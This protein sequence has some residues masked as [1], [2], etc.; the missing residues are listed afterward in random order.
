MVLVPFFRNRFCRFLLLTM[1]FIASHQTLGRHPKLLRL[2][3]KLNIHKAQAVGHLQYLWWWALDYAPSGDLSAL[4]QSEI[5]IASEWPG[6][7]SLFRDSLIE[8]GF[9]DSNG[10]IHDWKDH[11][12]NLMNAREWKKKRDRDYQ[13]RRR[14]KIANDSLTIRQRLANDSTAII[15]SRLSKSDKEYKNLTETT[16][17]IALLSGK[18]LSLNDKN[19]ESKYEAKTDIQKIVRGFKA[20]L[21]VDLDD[22]NWDK[23]Y[24][25]R[26][27]RPAKELL[28]LFNGNVS[29]TADCIDGISSILDKKN[30]SWTPETI[31]KHASD[32]KN[33]R[34]LK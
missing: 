31:V 13:L 6:E 30:L 14:Q 26:Y 10:M 4:S 28:T 11:S 20:V 25:R 9:L 2:A 22:R 33:G 19:V 29:A 3:S 7:T 24:F 16:E 32:W 17:S 8:C 15:E 12:G 34:L 1:S 18:E 21:G 27:S 23:V 5:S